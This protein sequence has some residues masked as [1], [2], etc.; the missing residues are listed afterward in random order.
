MDRAQMIERLMRVFRGTAP[1]SILKL[2]KLTLNRGNTDQRFM[3][4]GAAASLKGVFAL[5]YTN[6]EFEVKQI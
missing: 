2:G 3:Y 6:E 5:L 1:K 4:N